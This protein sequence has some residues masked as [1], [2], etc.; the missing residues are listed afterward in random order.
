M[1]SIWKDLLFMHGH[2]TRPED[3]LD[4]AFAQAAQGAAQRDA[5]HEASTNADD[6]SCGGCGVAA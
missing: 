5:R 6:L 4:D 2:F 1:A 3:V